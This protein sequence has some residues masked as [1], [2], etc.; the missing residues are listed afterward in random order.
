M[1]TTL[2]NA[3]NIVEVRKKIIFTLLMFVV[4]RL[5]AHIPVPG[6]SKDA[7]GELFS[8]DIWSLVDTFSGGAL[9]TFTVCA[10]GIMPYI[11]ASI[12]MNLLTICIPYFE[13]LAKEG[14]EGRKKMATITRYGAI[15]LAFIQAIGMTIYIR[16]ALENP[17]LFSCLVVVMTMT[18]GT[19]FLMWLGELITE[20]GI[21]NGISLI[22]FIG[23]VAKLPSDL[24]TIVTSLQGGQTNIIT[25]ILFAILA[26]LIIAGV[27]FIQEAQRRIP[28]QYTK[29]MV[30][31]RMYGGQGTHIPI[32]VNQT[33]VIPIIFAMSILMLPAYIAGL[34]PTNGVARFI[35]GMFSTGSWF[36]MFMYVLL[37]IFFTYFY[38]AVTFN[39]REIA[40]N[41][42]K[43][44]GFIPGLRPGKPTSEYLDRV[45]TRI[46]L[47][48][49]IFL[50]AIAVL[51]FL[52]SKFSGLDIYFGGT[53]LLI[54]VGVALD[55]MK[56]LDA[57]VME[58]QYSG[59]M[60]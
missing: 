44:G 31:R 28:V 33:G 29:R 5:A 58:R 56:Q 27:V 12:I 51:P 38:T 45:L 21:G 59:F 32:K 25:V 15:I 46:T 24:N 34:F 4:F 13:N 41:M 36:Y 3:W 7:L 19:C 40:E 49:A 55:T 17:S 22:I 2:K 39:C 43:N 57:Q 18:A 26:V 37:I 53:S 1:L 11:N 14:V 8:A 35:S 16:G 50:A 52:A 6:I 30:G 9:K 10:M 42:Q 60:K 23:I 48:G 47:A 20:H 54:V